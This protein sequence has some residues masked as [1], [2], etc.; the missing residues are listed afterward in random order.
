MQIRDLGWNIRQDEAIFLFSVGQQW[1]I[2]CNEREK[3][4]YRIWSS[5]KYKEKRKES[6]SYLLPCNSLLHKPCIHYSIETYIIPISTI[7][8]EILFIFVSLLWD[9]GASQ[10]HVLWM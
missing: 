3:K 4:N 1:V 8:V 10:S 6:I 7:F 2:W 5:R 9:R